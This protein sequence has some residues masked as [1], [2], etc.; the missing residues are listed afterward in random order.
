MIWLLYGLGGIVGLIVLVVVVG[1]LLPKAHIVSRRA[2]YKHGPEAIWNAIFGPPT[3]RSDVQRFEILPEQNG[4][5][6]WREHLKG[7]MKITLEA[8]EVKP[9]LRLVT[10]IIDKDLP[11][12]GTWTHAIVPTREGCAVT[13]TESGEVYNPIF[14]FMSRFVFGHSATIKRYLRD[15][16]KKFGEQITVEG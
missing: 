7:N 14:R 4:H 5:R 15:L 12:G 10:K 16:G 13:I 9:P 11:F 8:V 3:W 2:C 1:V 6:V